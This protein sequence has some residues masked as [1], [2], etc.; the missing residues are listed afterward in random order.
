L[1]NGGRIILNGISCFDISFVWEWYVT[2]D[3]MICCC[4]CSLILDPGGRTEWPSGR[5]GHTKGWEAKKHVF[6][7]I[8]HRDYTEGIVKMWMDTITCRIYIFF[9]LRFMYCFFNLVHTWSHPSTSWPALYLLRLHPVLWLSLSAY[10]CTMHTYLHLCM[11]KLLWILEWCGFTLVCCE[12][13]LLP[14][15]F[16]IFHR[17]KIFM[18]DILSFWCTKPFVWEKWYLPANDP[19]TVV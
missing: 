9:F 1:K 6:K 14:I 8:W 19:Y 18:H 3:C 12:S 11:L 2:H 5:K 16:F 15:L 7:K 13:L 4:G 10:A 17:R